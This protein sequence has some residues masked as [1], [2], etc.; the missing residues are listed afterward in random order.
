MITFKNI[1]GVDNLSKV[2]TSIKRDKCDKELLNSNL[3]ASEKR[4]NICY[5]GPRDAD[6]VVV[7]ANH[8]T[9]NYNSADNGYFRFVEA[10]IP[11]PSPDLCPYDYYADVLHWCLLRF[12]DS[13]VTSLEVHLDE[14]IDHCHALFI[15]RQTFHPQMG[16]SIPV[17]LCEVSS[18]SSIDYLN[19]DFQDEIGRR[20]EEILLMPTED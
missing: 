8:I 19:H 7:I 9:G 16:D 12:G 3:D 18:Q 5:W 15:P 17:G 6:S 1:Y 13:N 2:A 10:T 20:W 11:L 4:P 14:E